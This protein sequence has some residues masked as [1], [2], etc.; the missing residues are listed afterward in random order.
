MHLRT[1]N[2]RFH[3]EVIAA[4]LGAEGFVTQLRGNVGGPYP[5]GDTSVWV[6]EEDSEE[7]AELLLADEVEDALSR[8]DEDEG[9]PG[10]RHPLQVLASSRFLIVLGLALLLFATIGSRWMIG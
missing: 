5:I 6:A 7:A 4:R 10:P 8:M 1:V 9:P 2:T 3:A